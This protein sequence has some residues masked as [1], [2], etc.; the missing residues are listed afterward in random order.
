MKLNILFVASE[1]AP[2]AQVGG[3]GE[4][5]RSLPTALRK[6]DHD[7]RIFIPRYGG[8]DSKQ[9]PL[10]LEA[11]NLKIISPER[12][13]N[14]LLVCNVLKHKDEKGNIIAY[15][16]ENME[17][18]EKRA[19]VYGYSDDTTRWL[20]LSRGVLEFLKQSP[21][22]PD[23]IVSNDWQTGFVPNLLAT[24]YASDPDLS[25]IATVHSIH[26]LKHQGI[27]DQHFISEIDYDSGQGPLP[28]FFD[29][30]IW[31]IN[32]ARRGIL[33]A[34]VVNAVS[35]TYAKEIMTKEFGEMLDEVLRERQSRV[36]GILNGINTTVLDPERDEVLAKPFSSGKL[37]NRSANKAALQKRFG[38][39]DDPDAF[40]VAFVGRLDNQKG[41][42][43]LQNIAGAMLQNLNS[44]LIVL[45]DGDN[46]DKLYFQN[47]QRQYPGSVVAEL[48]FDA[49]LPRQIFAGADAVLVPSAFE[50]CGLVQMEAMRYGA[51]PI[52]RK[53]GGLADSVAD[54]VPGT[55]VGT[56]FVFE[57]Y[58]HLALLI[59]VVR[60]YET[61]KNKKAW[62]A[63]VKHAMEQDFSWG[64]SAQEYITLF[65]TAVQLHTARHA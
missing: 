27:F 7:V 34:D 13:P 51:I 54:Y 8:I 42:D 52:V 46:D 3:L 15:F 25:K 23:I 48:R 2:Y 50:P 21:W 40:V 1:A 22:K 11:S 63:L 47:L 38:L 12:D 56:G 14:G 32:G 26:N 45:G 59:A 29:K 9:F 58:D 60:A 49:N 28:Q 39:H 17:Y 18:Y 43:L 61:Y 10:E 53:V 57:K 65:K 24:E 5:M 20:L 6:L 44:Q 37:R 41:I 36:F 4:V 30:E 33:S 16:L 55:S 62:A 64:K 31:K 19:N 35:P